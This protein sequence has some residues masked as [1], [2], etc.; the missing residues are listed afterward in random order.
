MWVIILDLLDSSSAVASALVGNQDSGSFDQQNDSLS[1]S[2]P[3]PP[4][5]SDPLTPPEAS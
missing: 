4:V 5:D 3:V 1:R 2:V